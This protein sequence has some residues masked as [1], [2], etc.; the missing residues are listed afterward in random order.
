MITL[1]MLPTRFSCLV[2]IRGAL[3]RAAKEA[4]EFY[5]LKIQSGERPEMALDPYALHIS[6]ISQSK[7]RFVA[8]SL[9]THRTVL[10]R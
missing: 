1:K 9:P 7:T 2:F 8:H 4:N 6:N 10:H 5:T 3:H